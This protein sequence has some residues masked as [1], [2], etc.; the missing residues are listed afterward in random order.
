MT[1]WRAFVS[2]SNSSNE[3]GPI[4]NKELKNLIIEKRAVKNNPESDSK[5]GLSERVEYYILSVGFFNFFYD[6]FGCN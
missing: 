1:N 3:P 2:D 4:D 6:A 5:L